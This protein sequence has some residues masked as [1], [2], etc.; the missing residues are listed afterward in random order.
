[1]VREERKEAN[2]IIKNGMETVSL[3]ILDIDGFKG[4]PVTVYFLRDGEVASCALVMI[5]ILVLR[6]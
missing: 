3:D 2:K 1:M 5:M 6:E 4:D